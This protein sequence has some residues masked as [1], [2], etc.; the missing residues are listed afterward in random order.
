MNAVDGVLCRG[1]GWP[2][3]ASC[4]RVQTGRRCGLAPGR[5][6][7]IRCAGC[8]RPRSR[9]TA[10]TTIAGSAR[11]STRSCEATTSGVQGRGDHALVAARPAPPANLAPASPRRA[12]GEDRRVRRVARPDRHRQHQHVHARP[13]GRD[14]GRLRKAARPGCVL[15]RCR[16]GAHG[17]ADLTQRSCARGTLGRRIILVASRR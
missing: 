10:I 17:G 9:S 5:P 13:S 2:G 6:R 3:R 4:G 8:R 15:V 12:V 14:R 16:G 1:T 7:P 11:S